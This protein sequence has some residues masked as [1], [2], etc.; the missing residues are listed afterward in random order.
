[1][2]KPTEVPGPEASP[3]QLG[4]KWVFHIRRRQASDLDPN[5]LRLSCSQN[6]GVGEAGL[7]GGA[8]GRA[9][10]GRKSL[11]GAGEVAGNPI[12]PG[13]CLKVLI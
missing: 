3:V 2:Q 6:L 8:G 5:L 7:W 1:M 9:P 10:G 12:L 13:D 4:R 11:S